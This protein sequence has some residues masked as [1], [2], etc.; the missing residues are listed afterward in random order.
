MCAMQNIT[1][2]YAVNLVQIHITNTHN[3]QEEYNE[4]KLRYFVQNCE[5]FFGFF[6]LFVCF[7][8][9]M[10][11]II[12][13]IQFLISYSCDIREKLNFRKK[14]TSL[15]PNEQAIKRNAV[16]KWIFF[17][18]FSLGLFWTAFFFVLTTWQNLFGEQLSIAHIFHMYISYVNCTWNVVKYIF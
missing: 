4:R 6:L 17:Y 16:I 2:K 5:H 12:Q 18:I 10:H 9:C 15:K 3:A 7:K 11:G 13:T 14:K 8:S 1:L